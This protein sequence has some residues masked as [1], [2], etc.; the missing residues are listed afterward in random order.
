MI[1]QIGRRGRKHSEQINSYQVSSPQINWSDKMVSTSKAF[2][3]VFCS[4]ELL[5]NLENPFPAITSP[6]RTEPE[7]FC[8]PQ[9]LQNYIPWGWS[10]WCEPWQARDYFKMLGK[11]FLLER[12]VYLGF[13]FNC[14]PCLHLTIPTGGRITNCAPSSHY[15]SCVQHLKVS[16]IREMSR[17]L[18]DKPYQQGKSCLSCDVMTWRKTGTLC[19][20]VVWSSC[21]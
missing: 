1:W 19:T 10:T 13:F 2:P 18:E 5:T 12:I 15:K 6:Q 4:W 11:S 8:H 3:R 20:A 16:G 7:S 21:Y 14:N 9:T 17:N